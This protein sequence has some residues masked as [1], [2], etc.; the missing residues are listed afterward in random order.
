MIEFLCSILMAISLSCATPQNV[1][2]EIPST[3]KLAMEFLVPLV[4]KWEGKRNAAYLDPV[5]IPTIC[6]GHTRTVTKLD[7]SNGRT[8][9]DAQCSQ[10]LREELVEYRDGIHAFFTPETVLSSLP[11]KRDAAFSSFAYNVGINGAG[12][13]TATRRLNEGN[14]AGACEAITWWNKA[15]GRVLRGLVRRRSE[16]ASLCLAV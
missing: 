13:S 16:E 4:A 12:K 2:P 11:P 7:V 10:L 8:L 9:S 15:G 5:G 3:E 14:V 6:Y 1:P